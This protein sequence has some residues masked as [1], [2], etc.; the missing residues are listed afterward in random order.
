M[1]IFPKGLVHGFGRKLDI[2]PTVFLGNIG[3]GNVLCYILKRK[4]NFPGYKNRKLKRS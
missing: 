3:Q 2:F 1:D 4:N